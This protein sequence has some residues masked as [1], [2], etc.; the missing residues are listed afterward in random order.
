MQRS[1][2]RAGAVCR[3][4]HLQQAMPREQVKQAV[5]RWSHAMRCLRATAEKTSN[6]VRGRASTG[7]D[8]V[9]PA[10]GGEEG[11]GSLDLVL[12]VSKALRVELSNTR[13][14]MRCPRKL[15]LHERLQA[16]QARKVRSYISSDPSSNCS[17]V[18]VYVAGSSGPRGHDELSQTSHS[19]KAFA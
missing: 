3:L 12:I 15:L 6:G 13:N 10:G 14:L 16:L 5:K 2:S 11:G 8:D 4:L 1:L 19:A 7:V 9:G 17:T 18:I